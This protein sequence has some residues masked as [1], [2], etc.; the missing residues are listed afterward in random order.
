MN[1]K[2]VRAAMEWLQNGLPESD[3]MM[4]TEEELMKVAAHCLNVRSQVPWGKLIPDNLFRTFVL[5]PRVNNEDPVFYHGVIWEELKDRL[6]DCSMEEAI[7]R[8][9]LWCYEKAVYQSTDD[10]T[11]NPITIMKRAY[12][13]CGEESVLL[14]S[15]LRAC[16][17]PAR[18]VYVPR[19]SHCDDNHAWVE[20]WDG[21]N[22]NW[23]L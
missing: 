20:A 4:L 21:K 7:Q 23:M 1:Q 17:I 14:V 13:R 15:A 11:A 8:V 5:F 12:G 10:R 2:E 6:L 22:W 18:Q 16:G 19:W 3:R 9:N